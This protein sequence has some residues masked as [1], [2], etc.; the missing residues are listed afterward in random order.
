MATILES[1]DKDPMQLQLELINA[2]TKL[3]AEMQVNAQILENKRHKLELI[4]TAKEAL[5]ANK[6]NA[7][8]GERGVSDEEV[9]AYAAN[10]EKFLNS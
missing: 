7:P 4:K 2:Q 8:I 3:Q 9:V 5:I 1:E 6:S 10:L